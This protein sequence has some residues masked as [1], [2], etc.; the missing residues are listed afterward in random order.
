MSAEPLN[1][2]DIHE[3]V[4]RHFT[5]ARDCVLHFAANSAAK[6]IPK[7]DEQMQAIGE[8]CGENILFAHLEQDERQEV[9]D[10]MFECKAKAGDEV[11]VQVRS[12]SSR[13][14]PAV[15]AR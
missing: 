15:H 6:V 5:V 11:I 9:Y 12:S 14:W 8:A 4:V 2:H 1:P 13:P 10:A 7:T 3:R